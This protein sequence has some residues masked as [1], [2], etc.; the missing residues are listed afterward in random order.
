M[1]RAA[2]RLNATKAPAGLITKDTISQVRERVDIVN[3]VGSR[4]QLKKSGSTFIGLCPFHGEKTPS[5]HVSPARQ[6]FHCFGCGVDGDA[7]EFLMQHDGMEF[8]DAL[9]D[10]AS[11]LGVKIE[12]EQTSSAEQSALRVEHKTYDRLTDICKQAANLYANNL[13]SDSQAQAYAASRGLTQEVIDLYGIG[14]ATGQYDGLREAIPDWERNDDLIKAG[15][16]VQMDEGQHKGRRFDRFRDRLMFPIRDTKGRTIGFGG[17]IIHQ[18]NPKAAKYLNSPETVLFSKHKVLYGLHE[19]RAAIMRSK[20]AFVVEG[21]MDVVAMTMH[22]VPNAVAAMGTAMTQDHARLLLRFTRNICFLFD[23]DQAGQNAAWKSAQIVLPLLQSGVNVSFLSL[24]DNQDPDEYL[25]QHGKAAFLGLVNQHSQSLTTFI[26]NK[27]VATHGQAG[28]LDSLEAKANFARD[29]IDLA[30]QIPQDNP[31]AGLL[32]REIENLSGVNTPIASNAQ[33]RHVPA[34]TQPGHTAQNNAS[35]PAVS[36]QYKRP[37]LPPDQFKALKLAERSSPGMYKGTPGYRAPTFPSLDANPYARTPLIPPAAVQRTLWQQIIQAV[38][39]SPS[40]AFRQAGNITTLL[41]QE[42]PE[43][44]EVLLVFDAL[45]NSESIEDPEN[46]PENERQGAIDLLTKAPSL[47]QRLRR[48]AQLA[49][50]REMKNAG[51]ISEERYLSEA[52]RKF[53]D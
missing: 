41:N 44:L 5:F 22:G 10:L 29:A 50:L 6:R 11:R 53:H 15:L 51:E 4:V 42:T 34:P 27:L 3:E 14:Y 47:I 9:E 37:W 32:F 18:N 13:L 24:P 45:E 26:L 39:V 28:R 48:Q 2:N 1:S 17:R 36:R 35:E 20:Q 46:Q 33:A 16:V 19:A 49:H 21:Y 52:A 38:R 31:L 40:F 7:I 43:E 12:R 25:G 23:G 8:Q 30:N